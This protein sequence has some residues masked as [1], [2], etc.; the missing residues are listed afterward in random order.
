M[1]GN[2][3][4][5][6]FFFLT[7]SF[8][9]PHHPSSFV[10]RRCLPAER[11]YSSLRDTWLARQKEDPDPHSRWQQDWPRHWLEDYV[12]SAPSRTVSAGTAADP[13]LAVADIVHAV[14]GREPRRRYVP[15]TPNSVLFF[16]ALRRGWIGEESALVIKKAMV[17]PPSPG[18]CCGS[19]AGGS[20]SNNS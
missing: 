11:F 17:N 15:G 3:Q 10:A 9:R 14:A 13:S 18:A 6:A 4:I 8:S 5:A 12:V 19:S 2:K 1:T 7:P 16:E 20:S